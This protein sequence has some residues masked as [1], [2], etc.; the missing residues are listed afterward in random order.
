MSLTPISSHSALCL[1]YLA[2]IRA[3]LEGVKGRFQ[4]G[5]TFVGKH[6]FVK[7]AQARPPGF[8]VRWTSENT[9]RG[10]VR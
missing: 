1:K 4:M 9:D 7:A 10:D 2:T 5:T 3:W 6:L 8:R